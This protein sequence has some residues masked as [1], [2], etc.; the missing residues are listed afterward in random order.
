[1][2]GQTILK[3]LLLSISTTLLTSCITDVWTGATIIYDR[4]NIYKTIGDVRLAARTNRALFQDNRLK[5]AG[6]SIDVAIFKG[7]ILLSGHVPDDELRQEARARLMKVPGYRRLFNQLAIHQATDTTIQ[8]DWITAKIRSGI[9]ADSTIDPHSFKVVTSDRIVYLM[10]DVIP[11]EAESVIQIARNCSGVTRVVKL[12]QYY[13]L[14]DKP[15]SGAP[16]KNKSF[17]QAAFRG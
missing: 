8:D 17:T 13:N 7:D 9:F 1:M 11:S 5:C 2:K 4:H 15:M 14:S 12:F 10:G 3:C 6:C 16:K